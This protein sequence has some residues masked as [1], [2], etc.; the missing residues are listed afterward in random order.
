MQSAVKDLMFKFLGGPPRASIDHL[1]PAEIDRLQRAGTIVA[2]PARRRPRYFDGRFLAAPDLTAEQNYFL[3]RQADQARASMAGVIHG[4][5]V[6]RV[7]DTT[8]RIEAGNGVTP[9]GELVVLTDPLT[10]NLGDI[11]EVQRLDAAFG[12]DSIPN[13]PARRRSGLFVLALRP[14]EYTAN[15]IAAYPA[16]VTDR[17]TVDDGEIIEAVAVTLVP[18]PDDQ[19]DASPQQQR[20]HAAR[21]IF[22][23]R[24]SDAIPAEALPIAMM[25][26]DRGFVLWVDLY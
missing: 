21:R 1:P 25:Q 19:A 2:D 26:L 17:R 6:S 15:P 10:V 24:P 20:A 3:G 14:V 13:E 18:Y 8:L 23:D 9:A 22:V 7:D 16:S 5:E 12:L 4:L 11:A